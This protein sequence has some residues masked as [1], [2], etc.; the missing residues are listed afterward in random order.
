MDGR[1]A[2]IHVAP[3]KA[4]ALAVA[5]KK[6]GGKETAAEVVAAKAGLLRAL[7][8]R[9]RDVSSAVER[10]LEPLRIRKH[11][12]DQVARI[13]DGFHG[14]VVQ[15]C[16]QLNVEPPVAVDEVVAG[17]TFDEVAA[18]LRQPPTLARQA[19]YKASEAPRVASQEEFGAAIVANRALN[20]EQKAMW[21]EAARDTLSK[22]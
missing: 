17:L 3:V 18:Y 19:A 16:N 12:V 15:G 2:W 22:E 1:V 5:F 8:E 10:A 13:P 4:L 11:V 6:S 9:D 21:A 7:A 20:V 14:P